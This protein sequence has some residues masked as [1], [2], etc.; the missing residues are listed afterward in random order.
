MK[1][2]LISTI[3]V[4]CLLSGLILT[5]SAAEGTDNFKKINTYTDGLFRDV[6]AGAW[7]VQDVARAYELGLVDGVGGGKFG[8][9]GNITIAQTITLA[10]RLHSIYHT[11][12]ASFV[13]GQPWYQVYVDYAVANGICR[14]EKTAEL[15]RS[16][17]RREFAEILA[18]ALPKAAL[19]AI[20]SV[21]ALPDVENTAANSGIYLLYNAGVL[22]GSDDYG[23]FYPETTIRRSAVSAIVARMAD[24]ACRRTFTLKEPKVGSEEAYLTRVLTDAQLQALKN[25]DLETLR[26]TLSTVADVTAYLDQFGQ[27][28]FTAENSNVLSV[29]LEHYLKLARSRMTC[30]EFY[31]FLAAYCL[32]DDYIGL[33]TVTATVNEAETELQRNIFWAVSALALPIKGGYLIYS[34]A[35]DSALRDNNNANMCALETTTVSTLAGLEN[36]VKP[37]FVGRTSPIYQIF[38][39]PAD[40]KSAALQADKYGFKVARGTAECLYQITPEA[41]QEAAASVHDTYWQTMMNQWSDYGLTAAMEP[42]LTREQ[43]AALVGKSLDE[44]AAAVKTVG[45]CMYYYCASGFTASGGD[46]QLNV[47]N[48]FFWHYNYAPQMVLKNNYGCCGSISGLTAY[49]L[50]GD[51]DTVG[52]VGMTFEWGEGGG[53]VVNY[54]EDGGRWYIFDMINWITSAYGRDLN[55]VSG[56]SLQEA[57]KNWAD[58]T[59]WT[60]RLMY[61]YIAFDGDAPVGWEW[62]TSFISYLPVQYKDSAVILLETPSAGYVYQWVEVPE[63]IWTTMQNHRNGR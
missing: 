17:T 5:V 60:E 20:N 10:C 21:S 41:L 23:T 19:P 9:D 1:R 49:L 51:Y 43:A 32:S 39:L 22:T 16:A 55:L 35:A 13:Q 11:G 33:R 54:I 28:F 50:Q 6:A 40:T 18:A 44:I 42:T 8:P 7:Y 30:P 47:N 57:G 29:N 46:L 45:D 63:E 14:A 61:A 56:S 36:I 25:A 3:L 59:K 12:E 31:T 58:T 62:D 38:T 2:R 26:T 4:F 27:P 34:P 53:H 37:F 24:P 48:D 15:N 52:I